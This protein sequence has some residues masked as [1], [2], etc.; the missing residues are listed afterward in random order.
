MAKTKTRHNRRLVVELALVG[1]LSLH[2]FAGVAET[3]PILP[4]RAKDLVEGEG[5]ES[6]DELLNF[7]NI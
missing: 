4:R 1:K 6:D 3:S 7:R 5:R 2:G